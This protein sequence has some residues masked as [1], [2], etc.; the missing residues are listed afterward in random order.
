MLI[1]ST[2]PSIMASNPENGPLDKKFEKL[3]NRHWRIGMFPAFQWP[4][5]MEK[6]LMLR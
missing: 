2:E 5:S 6:G 4:L 3:V 1:M